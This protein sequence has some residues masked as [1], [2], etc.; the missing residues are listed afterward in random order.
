MVYDEKLVMS[1]DQAITGASAASTD[2]LDMQHMTRIGVGKPIAFL[3]RVT[4]AFNAED[5]GQGDDDAEL[6]IKVESANDASFSDGEYDV[7]T[8]T[9]LEKADLPLGLE[10]RWPFPW[11]VKRYVRFYYTKGGDEDFTAGK[12]TAAVLQG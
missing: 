10:I 11:R 3:V 9:G 1:K 6:A 5:A 2:I 4:E 7:Y 8:I 12:L